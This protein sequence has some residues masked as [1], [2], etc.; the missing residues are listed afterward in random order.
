MAQSRPGAAVE[1]H[2]LTVW[3]ELNGR[4]GTV[5][6]FVSNQGRGLPT[7]PIADPSPGLTSPGLPTPPLADPS[8]A[9]LET[10]RDPLTTPPSPI[11]DPALLNPTGALLNPTSDAHVTLGELPSA[12][13]EK[14]KKKKKKQNLYTPISQENRAFLK[15]RDFKRL[16][17]RGLCGLLCS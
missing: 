4:V 9:S 1:L 5:T 13:G 10:S 7:S 12:G 16:D 8:P 2:S 6:D 3:P 14:K 11:A 17:F 15:P